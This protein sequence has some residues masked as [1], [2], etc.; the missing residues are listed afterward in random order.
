MI[1]VT[2]LIKV[3]NQTTKMISIGRGVE[4][5]TISTINF[6]IHGSNTRFFEFENYKT[7]LGLNQACM[8]LKLRNTY[9]IV[10]ICSIGPI[11]GNIL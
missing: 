6:S 9:Y 10:V 8:L 7:S 4:S 3:I 11:M 5:F 1:G 2:S